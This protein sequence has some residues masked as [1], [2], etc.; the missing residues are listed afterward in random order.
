MESL[1][2]QISIT[3]P[4]PYNMYILLNLW[5]NGTWLTVLFSSIQR[6]GGSLMQNK[7]TMVCSDQHV[8]TLGQRN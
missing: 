3:C 6:Q 4:L 2:G 8:D 1:F 7:Q 5:V